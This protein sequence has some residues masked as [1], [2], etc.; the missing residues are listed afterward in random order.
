MGKRRRSLRKK[1]SPKGKREAQARP[2]RKKQTYQSQNESS[3]IKMISLVLK[4]FPTVMLRRQR[5]RKRR[6]PRFSSPKTWRRRRVMVGAVT[7]LK[8]RGRDGR[9][10]LPVVL[11]LP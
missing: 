8:A 11:D 7:S 1:T 3:F 2:K 4:C 5:R 6:A 9:E 10:Q